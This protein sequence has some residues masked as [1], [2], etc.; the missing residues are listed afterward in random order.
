MVLS[1]AS[2]IHPSQKTSD[3]ASIVL[4]SPL[5]RN[6]CS[7]GGMPLTNCQTTGADSDLSYVMVSLTFGRRLLDITHAILL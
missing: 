3:L 5:R 2:P 6:A 4:Q 7:V 1:E